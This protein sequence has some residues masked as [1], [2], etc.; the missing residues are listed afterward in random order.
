MFKIRRVPEGLSA[1][2]ALEASIPVQY[3]SIPGTRKYHAVNADVLKDKG[4]LDV[5]KAPI[6]GIDNHPNIPWRRVSSLTI[7]AMYIQREDELVPNPFYH[8]MVNFKRNRPP[9]IGF[10][11]MQEDDGNFAVSTVSGTKA[12]MAPLD[13]DMSAVIAESLMASIQNRIS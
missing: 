10:G 3:R 12:G 8:L 9:A 6:N 2:D 7:Q 4:I 13:A 11:L 5:I 1:S